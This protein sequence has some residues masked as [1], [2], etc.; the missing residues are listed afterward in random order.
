[1]AFSLQ[2]AG[3]AHAQ[4]GPADAT[5]SNEEVIQL[6]AFDVTTQKDYGYR[7]SNSIAGTRTNTAIKDIPV[8]IQV[9][10]KDL[11]DDLTIKNQVDLEAYNAALVNG[12]ADRH[13]DNVIQQSYQNF[14]FRGFRQNWGLRDGVRE[15]D[16]IDTQGLA[17]VEVVKGP[18]AALYGLAYPGGVMNNISKTVDFGRSFT[19]LRLTAGGEGDY[20]AALDSNVSATTTSNQRFGARINGV[21]EKSIDSREHSEGE[22]RFQSAMLA[23]QPTSST[24]AEFLVEH[25]YRE[26]PVGLGYYNTGNEAGA[27]GNH[28][29]IPMQILHPEIPWDWNW[30]N[31]KNADA[32]TTHL[33]RGMITQKLTEALQVRGYIQ[34]SSRLEESNQGW[35]YNGGENVGS[36]YD[37]ITN[38]ITSTYHYRDW[39]NQMHAY[40]ATGVYTVDLGPVKNT[41]AF[42][43]NVWG[44]RELSRSS[45]P[46]NPLATALVYPVAANI[47]TTLIPSFPPPDLV[48][49]SGAFLADGVTPN[50]NGYHHENNSNDYY[51]V[52]WQSSSFGD[53]L[54]TNIGVNKTNIKLVTWNNG[55][56]QTPD[57]QY[58]ASKVSPLFGAVYEIVPGFSVFG[59]HSTS[60]F[61]DSTK[62]SFGNQFA[63][64]TGKSWEGGFKVELLD[65]KIS[66]TASYYNI[67]Q[68]GGTQNTPNH[69]NINTTT[70]DRLSPEDRAV[71]FPGRTREDLFAAG[72]IIAGGEQQAKGFDIDI[73]F[74]P[75]R[76]LQIVTS[77]TH[78]DH[79]FV[80]SAVPETIGQTYP[81]AIKT[82]YSLLGKYSFTETA[83][84]GLELGFGASGGTK[85]LIDYQEWPSGSGKFVPRYEKGR[86]NCE[87]FAIYRFKMLD[88]NALVQLNVKNIFETPDYTGWKATGSSSVLAT[89]RY[90]VPNP[91]V[92]RLTL[93]FEF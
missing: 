41:F 23:W 93:G 17:R 55:A 35:D 69:E 70:W 82:R 22:I 47:D 44:E 90:E 67:E 30:S 24:T 39:G 56:S 33:Y 50:N 20:R 38:T 18:V 63:P 68:T 46:R 64:Q 14:L 40:G 32:L 66:G 62:D 84:K 85:A 81:Q 79:E 74:Q 49:E 25:A 54:K 80:T 87:V 1:V 8:N 61:P 26:K 65:G 16:P 58:E 88:R 19:E 36:G 15:Y 11:A 53:R 52:T 83:L 12:M 76:Q 13:S 28:S 5:K 75:T 77:F 73:V 72:D 78:V 27:P 2:L 42:G 71:R 57:N 91:A 51:F 21:Y 34:Y 10:T 7:A 60:L 6:S 29:S 37:A 9:F 45:G 4:S 48:P 31:G 92:Y 86:I 3:L 59:I 89:E 43:A